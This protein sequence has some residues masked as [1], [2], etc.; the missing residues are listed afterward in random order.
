MHSQYEWSIKE[1][2]RKILETIEASNLWKDVVDVC[3]SYSKGSG[4]KFMTQFKLGDTQYD[5]FLDPKNYKFTAFPEWT[6][7]VRKFEW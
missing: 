2:A 6:R 3:S 5:I 4:L 7:G 1:R